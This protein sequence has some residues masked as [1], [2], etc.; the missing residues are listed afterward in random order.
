MGDDDFYCMLEERGHHLKRL[1]S[2]EVDYFAYDGDTHNGPC[3]EKCGECWCEHCYSNPKS[4][5]D[6][7]PCDE[8]G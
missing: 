5:V 3:C 6:I 7:D 8:K 4:W 1:A 2:G